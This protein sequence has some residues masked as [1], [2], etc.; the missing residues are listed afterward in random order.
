MSHPETNREENPPQLE[1]ILR[2]PNSR[3]SLYSLPQLKRNPEFLPQLK[4]KPEF[5]YAT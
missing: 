3:G 1:G 2:C 5:P 4:R